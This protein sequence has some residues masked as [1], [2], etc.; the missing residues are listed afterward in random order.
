MT[1]DQQIVVIQAFEDPVKAELARARLDEEHIAC[2]LDDVNI[3]AAL[4]MLGG[5][6][7]GIRLVVPEREAEQAVKVLRE[8]ASEEAEFVDESERMMFEYDGDWATEEESEPMRT[9]E[10]VCPEC[11]SEKVGLAKSFHWWMSAAILFFFLPCVMPVSAKL[12]ALLNGGGM[13]MAVGALLLA[14][15]HREPR[16]CRD[17]GYKGQRRSFGRELS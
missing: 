4:P 11:E 15:L 17:C 13:A 12:G 7:G 5:A 3:N 14:S 10:L 8:S 16:V 1:E 2:R 9:T 6:V